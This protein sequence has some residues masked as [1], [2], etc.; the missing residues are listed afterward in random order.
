MESN[1]FIKKLNFILSAALFLV[2]VQSSNAAPVV[3]TAVATMYKKLAKDTTE[4]TKKFKA[5]VG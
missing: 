4:G 5:R 2:T 3:E 1:M